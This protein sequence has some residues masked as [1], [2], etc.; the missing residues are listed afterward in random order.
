MKS[1]LKLL[2]SISFKI[3]IDKILLVLTKFDHNL[4][5]F[6]NSKYDLHLLCSRLQ[7]VESSL[8][9]CLPLLIGTGYLALKPLKATG[10]AKMPHI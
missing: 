2:Q 3:L 7:S 1:K 8:D 10:A 4:I 6:V 5:V 9:F